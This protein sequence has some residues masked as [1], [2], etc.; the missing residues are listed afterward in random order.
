M[1]GGS[2]GGVRGQGGWT[3][4]AAAITLHAVTTA[5][6]TP[7]DNAAPA[8]PVPPPLQPPSPH[9]SRARRPPR[10]RSR[11]RPTASGPCFPRA[12]PNGTRPSASAASRRC[13]A[14]GRRSGAPRRRWW[15]CRRISSRSARPPAWGASDAARGARAARPTRRAARCR[16]SGSPH[17]SSPRSWS[18]RVC[19][20][21]LASMWLPA[22]PR[23]PPNSRMAPLSRRPLHPKPPE[24]RN[25]TQRGRPATARPRCPLDRT[26][27]RECRPPPGA[28]RRR[29]CLRR[30]APAA[31]QPSEL[32]P[33]AARRPAPEGPAAPAALGFVYA[34]ALGPALQICQTPCHRAPRG[35]CAAERPHTLVAPP[36][37]AACGGPTRRPWAAATD[38]GRCY[39][40]G[41]RQG[42]LATL[43]LDVSAHYL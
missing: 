7:L 13:R 30:P 11:W 25:R 27:R 6:P 32:E 12:P 15:R 23:L 2:R 22:S 16:A 8:L 38:L 33:A 40:L 19:L 34:H 3:S 4:A 24:T 14:T 39:G 35:T 41:A 5:S 42:I 36:H 1:Q 29:R 26:A 37:P 17:C 10:R 9:H 43:R 18:G 20:V 31:C 28:R 21:P